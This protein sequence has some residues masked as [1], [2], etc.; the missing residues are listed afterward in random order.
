MQT[1]FKGLPPLK[2]ADI[3]LWNCMNQ[4]EKIAIFEEKIHEYY[5]A[6]LKRGFRHIVPQ[7]SLQNWPL[8]KFNISD[9]Y[10]S[11][12]ENQTVPEDLKESC[13]NKLID[14]KLMYCY[15]D[16]LLEHFYWGTTLIVGNN[17]L[18]RLNPNTVSMLRQNHYKVYLISVTIENILDFFEMIFKKR[19][20]NYKRGKWQKV[21]ESTMILNL[22]PTINEENMRTLIAF[23]EKYRTA[24]MHKFSA[25]RAFTAKNEWNHF[26]VEE[27]LIRAILADITSYFSKQR[28]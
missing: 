28:T 12:C 22:I 9:V 13:A 26:Q 7:S 27:N 20:C 24:E 3:E 11:I 10:K 6:C 8:Y 15:L 2:S 1:D 17:N 23:K 25:V 19:I 4:E 21:L 16:T 14:I 18:E 5:Q